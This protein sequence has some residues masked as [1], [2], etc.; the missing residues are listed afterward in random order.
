MFRF[1]E[2]WAK[3]SSFC[4]L[5]HCHLS[6]RCR[7]CLSESSPSCPP[8]L[9]EGSDRGSVLPT[10]ISVESVL[11]SFCLVRLFLADFSDF[12]GLIFKRLRLCRIDSLEP[13]RLGWFDFPWSSWFWLYAATGQI[14][15]DTSSEIN[16]TLV[17]LI[18]FD[19][20]SI[21]PISVAISPCQSLAVA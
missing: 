13:F 8:K 6:V 16:L 1:H 2:V 17:N 14:L 11:K 5:G 20:G 9:P 12:N 4:E 18:G 7:L 10:V 15:A 3:G 19:R 21:F